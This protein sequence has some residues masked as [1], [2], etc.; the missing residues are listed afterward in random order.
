LLCVVRSP[1][2]MHR[3][4]NAID[5]AGIGWWAGRVAGSPGFVGRERELSRLRAV[6]RGDDRLLLVMGDAGV[7]KTRLVT[8][9]MRRLA[10]EGV[11]AVWGGCLPMRET[12]PLLPLADA[13]GE[14]SKI[15][16]GDVL[17]SALAV[18]PRYVREELARLL[19]ELGSE[20]AEPVRAESGLRERLFAAISDLFGAAARRRQ[21]AM[22]V[23]DVHWADAA[24]LDCLTFLTRARRDRALL[25]VVTCRSDEA[26][27]DPEVVDWLAHVRERGGV[28]EVRLGPLTRDEVAVQV[29]ALAGSPASSTVVDELYARTEGNPFFTE[30]LVMAAWSGGVLDSRAELPVRL[31]ELLVKRSARCSGSARTVLSTLAVAGRP[32]SEELI[33]A[34]SGLDADDVR[35]GLRELRAARLLADTVQ[36]G[37][38]RPRHALL[39]EAVGADLLPSERAALHVR[40]ALALEAAG[41]GPSAA[42]AAEHWAAAGCDAEE[43][44]ARVRA[45]EAAEH[46]FGYAEA[47]RHWERAI[48]LWARVPDPG[49]LVGI[50]LPQMYLRGQDALYAAGDEERR[51]ALAEAAYRRFADHPDP[52][53]IASILLRTAWSRW[54]RSLVDVLP[55][56]ERALRLF[57]QL[58]PS[59]DHAK[60][61]GSY[62]AFLFHR[63]GGHG[64]DRRAALARGLEIAEAAGA[65]GI[66]AEILGSLAHDECMRGDVTDGFAMFER[67]R[68]LAEA[69]SDGEA[70]LGVAT[71]ET[72]MLLKMAMF[73]RAAEVGLRAVHFARENGRYT[74]HIACVAISNAAEALLA[75]GRTAE[76]AQLVDPL[77]DEPADDGHYY[78]VHGERAEIDLLRSHIEAAT[79]RLQQIQ[80]VTGGVS[81][82]D[83]A[84]ELAQLT[85][86]I[87]VW[88]GRPNDALAEVRRMLARIETSDLAPLCGWL[89]VVG[90][91]ACADLA[92]QGQA[93]RDDSTTKAAVAAADDLVAWVDRMGGD[94]FADHPYPATIPAERATWHAERSRLPGASDPATW[95]AAAD[96]WGA[97]S[98]AHRA[99]YARWRQAEAALLAG[100]PS[101][102]VADTV[103]SAASAANGH[104]PLLAAIRGLA[105]RARIPLD[106]GSALAAEPSEAAVP[107]GLTERELLVLRL[108]VAGRSNGEIGAELFISRKTASVHVSNI[109]RKL[110]VSTRVQAAALAERAGLVAT[111]V[112]PTVMRG[113]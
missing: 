52:A 8:E 86:E 74:S 62:A 18:A 7:G 9:G 73:D 65:I 90:M 41:D 28:A 29:T 46:V 31:A 112:A 111:P 91:R 87:E 110:G 105:E 77:T 27:L 5:R 75:Q 60:A 17:D 99:A 38:Q 84:R 25:V 107:Y 67:A 63:Q 72:D 1:G 13:L 85:A 108:L 19:P 71:G 53:V 10:S 55:L 59:V 14:L 16:R 4:R 88:A 39:A 35:G 47:A 93:H 76:A 26:P 80:V 102:A 58:P 100:E 94:P 106:T 24:T 64:D 68:S 95:Q 66:A 23:E 3:T 101:A 43:L 96:A 36:R 89:L 32:M 48:E 97:L 42:E 50:D 81:S 11:V 2:V 22:V 51:S 20:S 37:E 21:V 83:N 44:P 82:I 40:M 54:E 103:R 109:L 78:L 70:L 33:G 57:E 30:Q 69:C 113:S 45:A 98:F 34:V 56:L 104:V 79:A 61:L 15:D 49:Q 6:V 12:L 92:E